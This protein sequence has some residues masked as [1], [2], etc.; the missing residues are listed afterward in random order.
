MPPPKEEED[1]ERAITSRSEVYNTYGEFALER[2]DRDMDA[3][4]SRAG[5]ELPSFKLQ[6]QQRFLK[7][8]VAENPEWKSLLLY[9]QIGSGKTC[10]SITLAEEYMRA[11]PGS[12]VTVI[13]PARL[14]TNYTDELVSPCARY[15]YVTREEAR[16]L[17]DPETKARRRS[18]I[19]KACEERYGKKYRIMSIERF[20]GLA[21][22]APHLGDWVRDFTRNQLVIVDEVHN[23]MSTGYDPVKYERLLAKEVLA[24][25]SM[26]SINTVIF[27]FMVAK[28]DPSCKMLFLTATPVFDHMTQFKELVSLL[29]PEARDQVSRVRTLRETVNLLRGKVSFFPGTSPNA[30]PKTKFAMHEVNMSGT[31]DTVIA[32]IQ[33]NEIK[34]HGIHGAESEAFMS[35]QRQATIACLPENRSVAKNLDLVLSDLGE[36]APKVKKV[37]KLIEKH[38]VG[39]HLVY[40]SF[41]DS[42][43]RVVEAALRQRGWISMKEAVADPDLW[44]RKSKEYKVY[45]TWSGEIKDKDKKLIKGVVNAKDNIDG[46]RVRVILGSPSIKEGVSFLHV[47]HMHILD[48]VWNSSAKAQVEGRA[49]RFC[50]HVDIPPGHPTLK[51]RVT[52]HTYKLVPREGGDGRVA[53]T[54][55]MRIYDSI[56]PEKEK[57]ISKAEH[58]LKRVSIDY[59]L[60]RRLHEAEVD[61]WNG[62]PR[63]DPD[64]TNVESRSVVNLNFEGNSHIVKHK[65]QK[66]REANT[67]P[68]ARRPHPDTG[69][70]PQGEGYVVRKNKNDNDCCYKVRAP[71]A[72]KNGKKK[73]VTK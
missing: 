68:K 30:Y 37:L 12:S 54:S 63:T 25:K 41:V 64:P 22:S 24:K 7:H 39:K 43:T 61:P 14:L 35:L 31:Q 9:H 52:V 65:K 1:E 73:T 13:L 34:M 70:C 49:I 3:I 46:S 72:K 36:Y 59:H 27:K 47:Q 16:E 56:I 38:G 66:A 21:T 42:G 32:D 67:C 18:A 33:A 10:T 57:L 29:N 55:D 20:V 8:Y 48:P 5:G 58:L 19:A 44:A 53:V 4:C 26:D 17:A 50:S 62:V 15:R 11:N 69:L 51:R 23:L 6:V 40:S 28:A 45:A 60:F 71:P 2:N